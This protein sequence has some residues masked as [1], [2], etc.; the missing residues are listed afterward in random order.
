MFQEGDSATNVGSNDHDLLINKH[1]LKRRTAVRFW[2]CC[3]STEYQ[4][5]FGKAAKLK[6]LSFEGVAH[7]M[8][9][10][11]GN[12]APSTQKQVAR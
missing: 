1:M 9:N 2:A 10:Q 3:F 5:V 6:T 7:R 4:V 12:Q 11:G 8:V